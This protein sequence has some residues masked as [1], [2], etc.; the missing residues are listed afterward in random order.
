[1]KDGDVV[2]EIEEKKNLGMVE[3]PE[4][5]KKFDHIER[6][7]VPISYKIKVFIR[8]GRDGVSSVAVEPEPFFK[9]L[10]R[11]VYPKDVDELKAMTRK[12]MLKYKTY[13]G[14]ILG[15]GPYVAKFYHLDDVDSIIEDAIKY[16]KSKGFQVAFERL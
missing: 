16:S 3:C 14:Y 9:E 15:L 8:H 1:M 12:M 4:C 11:T 7:R 10:E 13:Q 2:F 5:G 6:E